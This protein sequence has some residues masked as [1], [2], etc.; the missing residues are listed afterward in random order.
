MSSWLFEES[1]VARGFGLVFVTCWVQTK[2]S[3]KAKVLLTILPYTI[4]EPWPFHAFS[5]SIM[6][7]YW[8]LPGFTWKPYQKPNNL[9]KSPQ[10]DEILKSR[11]Y[12]MNRHDTKDDPLTGAASS[13]H[14]T[15][16][17]GTDLCSKL[18][19]ESSICWNRCIL[20]H[21]KFAR[22]FVLISFLSLN[23]LDIKRFIFFSRSQWF[24]IA[25]IQS[26]L[27]T[28]KF[29]NTRQ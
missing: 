6:A 19:W 12:S 17:P 11:R 16:Y 3:E 21:L 18:L 29:I 9:N 22:N 28:N 8:K 7:F 23:Y 20:D 15:N 24:S 26:R 1:C 14:F 10:K 27:M 25:R 2:Y 13:C 4:N 5:E